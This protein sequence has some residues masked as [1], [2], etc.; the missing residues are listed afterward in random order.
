M[1][2]FWQEWRPTS[3]RRGPWNPW[4]SHILQFRGSTGLLNVLASF[5]VIFSHI[6]HKTMAAEAPD[7]HKGDL[8]RLEDGRNGLIG[9]E[10]VGHREG[11]Q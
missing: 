9:A 3:A 7:Q 5:P 6:G 2:G 8:G 4:G 10:T 11:I 1:L